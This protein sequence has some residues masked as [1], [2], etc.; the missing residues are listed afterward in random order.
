MK[1]NTTRACFFWR[2]S[3]T[4]VSLTEDEEKEGVRLCVSFANPEHAESYANLI[5]VRLRMFITC[6][7][8]PRRARYQ[9]LVRSASAR[10][11]FSCGPKSA[12]REREKRRKK[13]EKRTDTVWLQVTGGDE[14]KQERTER[15]H[16][17]RNFTRV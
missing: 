12:Q 6:K 1:Y 4:I 13:R 15:A 10:V 2:A 17:A 9:C 8:I 14:K 3:E 7:E 11:A 16:F 5:C